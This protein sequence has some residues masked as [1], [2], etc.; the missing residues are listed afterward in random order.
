[1]LAQQTSSFESR[2]SDQLQR[3]LAL[4]AVHLPDADERVRAFLSQFADPPPYGSFKAIPPGARVLY[5]QVL[6]ERG[7]QAGACFL[8][9]AVLM[10]V[11]ASLDGELLGRLP[12]R[13]LAHQ[14]R[15]FARIAN[16]DEAFL[17]YCRLDGDVFLKEFGLATLRLYAGASSVI[18]PRAGMGRSILWQGGL[19]QLPGRALLF[20]RAGGFKPYFA[21]HVNRLYQDEFNEEGRNECYRCCVDLYDLHPDALGMIAGS[22]FYD[23]VVEII[24]PHLAY[25]RT[26]PEEGGARALFVAHD[27]QAVRNATAT[28]E[29]R[30]ALHAAGQ[31]RP[32]SWALVWPKR[33]QIDWAHRHSKDKN[34]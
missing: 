5:D 4:C 2:L 33:A 18:D 3:A 15:Q 20:A 11:R 7:E 28:S 1:M 17:P 13:V 25:L 29:K 6:E 34:D 9:A 12:P 16:H 8:L 27:E 14:L 21:I 31:Y 10:G 32:A 26:V 19:L 22:W 30:R 24:S 23:P